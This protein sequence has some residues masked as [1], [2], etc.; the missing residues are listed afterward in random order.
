MAILTK[1]RV[2]G[3]NYYFSDN[4]AVCRNSYPSGWGYSAIFYSLPTGSQ[5]QGY[6]DGGC[7][8]FLFSVYGPGTQCWKSGGGSRA[9]SVNWFHSSNGKRGSEEKGCAIP[10]AFNYVDPSGQEQSLA[11]GSQEDSLH[12]GELYIAGNFTALAEYPKC[13]FSPRPSPFSQS[14]HAY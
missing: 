13:M 12:I 1:R 4:G 10:L 14:E 7:K 2:A 11:I 5:G 9:D 8:N 6:T 3:P